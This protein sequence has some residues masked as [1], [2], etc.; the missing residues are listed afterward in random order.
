MSTAM[1]IAQLLTEGTQ[2]PNGGEDIALHTGVIKSWDESSGVNVVNV[3]GKDLTNLKTINA[4]IGVQY[5]PGDSVVIIRK[6]T[7]Y[8]IL[9]KVAAPGGNNA[10]LIKSAVVNS[11]Q[12][13]GSV[14][15]GDLASVGPQVT[16]SIG[17]SRRALVFA[18]SGVET[19][20]S[21]TGSYTG[22]W[23]TLAVS[24]AST[25]GPSGAATPF[26]AGGF[27]SWQYDGIQT[28][29]QTWLVTAADG[30]NV[31]ANTFTLKYAAATASINAFFSGRA[32]AVIPF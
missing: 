13:T 24:G 3:N 26:Y 21:V 18:N 12:S 8:F 10:N 22:G 16:L 17:S 28:C 6:Q 7:Q 14:N 23:F 30:L 1:E 27:V 5:R 15:F 4:G 31:G 19:P 2:G 9:G 11:R 20:T 29:S 25:I 32:L